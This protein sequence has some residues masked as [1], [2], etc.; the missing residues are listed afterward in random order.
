MN[1]QHLRYAVEVEKTHSISEAAEN[2]F[3]GQPNLSRAIRELETMLGI[4]I[5]DRTPKGS[6]PTEQ[7]EEFLHFARGILAQ[8]DEMT[9][10]YQTQT[11]QVNTFRLSVAR[12]G[13]ISHVFS[14]FA[15]GMGADWM[16]DYKETNAL[17]SIRN[18][19][20]DGYDLGI[21]RYP[22]TYERYFQATFQEKGLQSLDI[23]S[24]RYFALM[25][26][27]HPI[28]KKKTIRLSDLSD[29]VQ[30]SHG[31]TYVPSQ[32]RHRMDEPTPATR[33]IHIYERGSQYDLIST[34]PQGAF[35]WVS[36]MPAVQLD[37]Y[38]L[39]LKPCE[40]DTTL[41]KDVLIFRKSPMLSVPGRQ[42]MKVLREVCAELS[43][44]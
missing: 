10:H 26:K 40:D 44:A 14:L 13:Y 30:I 6:I 9:A 20:E 34:L 5:F 22:H 4:T 24:F 36:P 38:G 41:H 28:A 33:H 27:N 11:G 18:V 42:F 35:M 1:I 3:M 39:V 32:L 43:Q 15:A 17:R 19:T 25:R 8:M 23:W 29:F 2:L 12:A 37:R 31:D 16:L 21:V 7:G